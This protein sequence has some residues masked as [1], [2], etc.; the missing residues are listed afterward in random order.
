MGIEREVMLE[1]ALKW[2]LERSIRAYQIGG[3]SHVYQGSCGCCSYEIYNSDPDDDYTANE[4]PEE[5]QEVIIRLAGEI[6]G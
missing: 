2:S 4:V 6:E 3:I 5:F 1:K